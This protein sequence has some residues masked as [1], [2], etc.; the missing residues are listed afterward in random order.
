MSWL[1][2]LMSGFV[3]GPLDILGRRSPARPRRRVQLDADGRVIQPAD[4]R[5]M[6]GSAPPG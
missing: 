5:R 1:L 3:R 4:P 6:P 2:D